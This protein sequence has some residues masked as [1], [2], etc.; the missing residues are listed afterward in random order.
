MSVFPTKM[1]SSIPQITT[2][3]M[4][5][6]DRAMMFDYKISLLQM[7]ENAGRNLAD[8][9]QAYLG[10]EQKISGPVV[11]LAGTGG[12][13]GGVLVA[14]RHL[15]NRGY[16]VFIVPVKE[17]S[18]ISEVTAHQMTII[19]QMTIPVSDCSSVEQIS[20]PGLILDGLIGYSLKGSPTGK[21]ANLIR[22][23]NAQRTAVVSLDV[24][25][26]MDAT[27]GQCH[28]P[29]ITASAT[30]TLA[31]PKTGFFNQEARQSFGQLFVADIS[32]PPQLYVD[33]GIMEKP[34]HMFSESSILHLQIN[35]SH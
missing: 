11:V 18:A 33:L 8:F 35:T 24:P 6:V 3:E 15:S 10:D 20:S 25:S 7:M 32:V 17:K 5:E 31:L 22:W 1:L 27:T 4:I 23:A 30:L 26:G 29:A 16:Q 28:I 34:V 12:N 9:V 14:A 2:K 21:T 13:G 19:E